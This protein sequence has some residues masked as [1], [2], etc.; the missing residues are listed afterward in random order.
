MFIKMKKIAITCAIAL[1]IAGTS[2]FA[3]EGCFRWD[4][5]DST[6]DP[7]INLTNKGY[8]GV[9]PYIRDND[10]GTP[11][12]GKAYI[13]LSREAGG[14]SKGQYCDFGGKVDFNKKTNKHY[15]LISTATEELNQESVK[16]LSLDKKYLKD[17]S[18]CYYDTNPNYSKL[19]CLTKLGANNYVSGDQLNNA[20]AAGVKNKMDWKYIE[21]D[22]FIWVSV[23]SLAN[24]IQNRQWQNV[25]VEVLPGNCQNPYAINTKGL[26]QTRTIDLRPVFLKSLAGLKEPLKGMSATCKNVLK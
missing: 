1:I 12:K 23:S 25:Q 19:M 20:R 24:A 18:Y 22:D 13:L 17:H 15:R 8:A 7:I 4:A 21:K 11:N 10:K 3:S 6:K 9:L 14:K 5:P 16:L 2:C 26:T